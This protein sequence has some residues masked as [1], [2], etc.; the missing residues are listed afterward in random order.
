MRYMPVREA[1]RESARQE[2][3]NQVLFFFS[4]HVRLALPRE[5]AVPNQWY[6]KLHLRKVFN[7]FLISIKF[8]LLRGVGES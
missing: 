8:P 6:G 4:P 2:D 7:Y 1:R 3:S 5:F